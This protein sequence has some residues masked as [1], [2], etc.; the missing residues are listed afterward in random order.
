MNAHP[1]TLH[2][3]D[4]VTY[5]AF[6]CATVALPFFV[7]NFLRYRSKVI[8]DRTPGPWWLKGRFPVKSVGGFV[9]SIIVGMTSAQFSQQIAPDDVLGELRALP[10]DCGIFI[11]GRPAENP[12]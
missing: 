9:V 2:A 6:I 4:V 11:V 10:D 5:S 1:Q 7:V 3:L 12:R 8:A